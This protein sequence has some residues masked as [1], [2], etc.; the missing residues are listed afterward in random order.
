[1]PSPEVGEPRAGDGVQSLAV[2]P[3]DALATAA[4]DHDQAG[5]TQHAQ[6]TGGGGPAAFEAPRD[7]T[8]GHLATAKVQHQQ[9][10][11]T[12]RVGERTK[13][14][15]D[16][17]ERRGRFIRRSTGRSARR[18]IDRSIDRS[19]NRAISRST[20]WTRRLIHR[21]PAGLTP[22]AHRPSGS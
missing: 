15:I 19:T 17:L 9:D 2:E 1:M 3:V 8:G 20:G 18:A 5:V 13:D 16:G 4:L 22:A 6:V 7:L 12:R 14:G 21:L 11:T 10:V